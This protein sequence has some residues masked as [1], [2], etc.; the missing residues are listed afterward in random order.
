MDFGLGILTFG[1]LASVALISYI[2]RRQTENL[3]RQGYR[4]ALATGQRERVVTA[5]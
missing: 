5:D 4:S 1:T 3:R 2:N